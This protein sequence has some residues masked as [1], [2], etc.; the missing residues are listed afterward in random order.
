MV[1]TVE[2]MADLQQDLMDE[3]TRLRNE[4]QRIET[5]FEK[6]T[7]TNRINKLERNRLKE[8]RDQLKS[9]AKKLKQQ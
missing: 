3:N 5:M 6:I 1:S 8:E 9:H 4:M 7:K 2:E